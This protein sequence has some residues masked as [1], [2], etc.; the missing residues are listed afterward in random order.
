[1]TI[2]TSRLLLRPWVEADAEDLYQYAKNP[3]VGPVAG[4]PI[5]TSVE[6]SREIIRTV[7][8][9]PETY[10]LVLKQ[11]GRPVGSI[12]L[13]PHDKDQPLAAA[14]EVGYWIG[15]PWWGRG[16]VP[17]AVEALLRRCFADL[18][19]EAVW[20][21]YFD[22]NHKS[23]RVQEKC[24]FVY[25]HTDPAYFCVQLNETRISHVSCLTREQWLAR[26]TEEGATDP[27]NKNATD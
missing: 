18:G 24:G 7:L 19:S 2:E 13:F 4:W 10:A 25:H 16:L 5:H 9:E 15:V 26:Q 22:G 20:C 27:W 17:E 3:A 6:N 11:T 14:P 12:G 23:R 21:A 1:M 8:A